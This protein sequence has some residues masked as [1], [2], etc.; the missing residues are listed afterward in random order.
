[1]AYIVFGL[2]SICC[3]G[4]LLATRALNSCRLKLKPNHPVPAVS[5][6]LPLPPSVTLNPCF[7][8]LFSRFLLFESDTGVRWLLSVN[9]DNIRC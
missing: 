5:L 1:M 3:K 2:G 8:T 9:E 4:H 7:H 6:A